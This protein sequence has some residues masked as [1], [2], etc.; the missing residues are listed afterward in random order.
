MK[1]KDVIKKYVTK[2]AVTVGLVV[3]L[4]A[5]G[6]GLYNMSS[7]LSAVRS[8]LLASKSLYS[9]IE[10]EKR[11]LDSLV[12]V[13]K[14]SI[15][16]RDKIITVKDAE[17]RQQNINIDVLRYRLDEALAAN[18]V[19]TPDSSYR[20]I[21]KRVKAT[22]EQVYKF[23]TTQVKNIHYTYIERDGLFSLNKKYV[24]IIQ[25]LSLSSS[26]KDSQITDLKNL[27]NVYLSK[28]DMCR[29]E[30][31]A[32]VVEID[33]LNKSV[34]QQ[35]FMKNVGIGAAVGLVTYIII[36]LVTK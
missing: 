18:A 5:G 10:A 24:L 34:K 17:I 23:D 3:L 6:Y 1:L 8:E 20:Y 30:N 4:C 33:G 13:Y 22:S 7:K 21:N 32:Y 29:K 9:I 11:R 26:L 25:D 31:E 2:S 14:G 28:G 36:N 19:V 27:N 35:K 16:L 12:V 15:D